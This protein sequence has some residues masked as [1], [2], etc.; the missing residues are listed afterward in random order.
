MPS[1]ITKTY[2]C[3]GPLNV[4]RQQKYGWTGWEGRGRF[5][6]SCKVMEN[7]KKMNK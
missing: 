6:D 7:R 2:T 3:V 4:N 5:V 1:G